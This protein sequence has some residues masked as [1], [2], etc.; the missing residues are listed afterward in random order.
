MSTSPK[1]L[2]EEEYKAKLTPQ[3]YSVAR[4]SGTERPF[5]GHFLHNKADGVYTCVCCDTPVF[6]SKTKFD[7]GSGWPS[8]WDKLPSVE[9]RSDVSHGMHRTEVRCSKCEAHLGHV[10]NDGPSETTGMRY[11]INSASLNFKP[12]A[13]Q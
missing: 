2:S 8:Y 12:R 10:F 5:T 13:A 7:S 3:Q 9:E 11:C 1:K 4:G 6:D